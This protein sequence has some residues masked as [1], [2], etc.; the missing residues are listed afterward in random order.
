M[1][2]RIELV[3]W[4]FFAMVGMGL[5]IANVIHYTQYGRLASTPAT[6][7]GVLLL[8]SALFQYFSTKVKKISDDNKTKEK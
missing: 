3:L 7:G 5:I 1:K 2:R 4:I 6:I 8:V